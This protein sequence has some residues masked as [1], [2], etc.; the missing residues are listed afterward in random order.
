MAAPHCIPFKLR[1]SISI[2]SV[3]FIYLRC[4]RF[5]VT[6]IHAQ[7]QWISDFVCNFKEFFSQFSFAPL[8]IDTK[9]TSK[10]LTTNTSISSWNY[11]RIFH[12]R[13]AARML[14]HIHKSQATHLPGIHGHYWLPTILHGTAHK[15]REF[16]TLLHPHWTV[17]F[18]LISKF[19][20]NSNVGL[21]TIPKFERETKFF[22]CS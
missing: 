20:I 12:I 14:D 13:S 18:V 17:K 7:F 9:I 11:C 4:H 6:L 22:R 8:S 21:F 2:H 16:F 5:N 1:A 19:S 10:H 15:R 3:S